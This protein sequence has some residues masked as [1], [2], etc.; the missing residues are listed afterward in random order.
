MGEVEKMQCFIDGQEYIFIND[1]LKEEVTRM[2]YFQLA[3]QIYGLKFEKWFQSGYCDNRFV[4]YI[5]M[6]EDIAVSSVA[7]CI[8]DIS[9]QD[10]KKRYVQ[11]STV[12]TLPEYRNKGLNRY[13]MEVVLNEWKDKCDAIYLLANDSVIDFYPKFGFD[14][15]KEFEYSKSIS[16]TIGTYRKL[17][18][19]DP[20]DWK[21]IISKYMLGN[22]FS[23]FKI[24]HLSLFVFHCIQF[25]SK[26]IY[27]ID[28]YDAVVVAQ[29]DNNRLICYDIFTDGNFR[30]DD[31]LSIMANEN[32]DIICLGF[33]PKSKEGYIIEESQEEDTHL[34]VL[35]G[36]KNIFKENKVMFPM[37]SRA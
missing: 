35:K 34:F 25:V 18:I 17:D 28:Q 30:V 20:D 4:P 11:I 31:I 10:Q 32:T 19:E 5:I 7:V 26:D 2:R 8:N 14:E 6:H 27:Y 23:E 3:K 24:D 12:M 22:P 13:L 29:Y 15:Y 16:K 1:A 21:L 36:K 9:W 37:L 33:T